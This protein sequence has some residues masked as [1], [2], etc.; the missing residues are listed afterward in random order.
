VWHPTI[1]EEYAGNPTSEYS[2]RIFG[3]RQAQK[4]ARIKLDMLT[5]GKTGLAMGA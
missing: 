5:A 3:S 2:G 4:E 1:S